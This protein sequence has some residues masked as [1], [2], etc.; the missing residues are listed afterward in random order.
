M[1]LGN[2]RI[3]GMANFKADFLVCISKC[4]WITTK[5]VGRSERYSEVGIRFIHLKQVTSKLVSTTSLIIAEY[6]TI[7]IYPYYIDD[8]RKKVTQG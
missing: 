6:L 1:P 8:K 7:Y 2:K 4:D 5:T 3:K